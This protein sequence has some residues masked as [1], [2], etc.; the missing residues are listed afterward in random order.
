MLQSSTF[1]YIAFCLVLGAVYQYYP[2]IR[3]ILRRA[4]LRG[5]KSSNF[6]FGTTNLLSNSQTDVVSLYEKWAETYGPVF[7]IPA[8]FGSRK[9]V[10]CDPKAVAHFYSL[11]TIVYGRDPVRREQMA[12]FVMFI[13][14][15]YDYLLTFTR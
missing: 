4:A 15:F 13:I 6:V 11:E 7:Q 2:L 12:N 8:P 3:F 1:Y 9:V 14:I 5:P 10:L